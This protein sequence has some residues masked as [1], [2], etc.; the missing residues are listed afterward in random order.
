MSET[1]AKVSSRFAFL[2]GMEV[3]PML[4]KDLRQA[5]RSWTVIGAVL[6]LMLIFFGFSVAFLLN[7]EFSSRSHNYM[8]PELFGVVSSV[9]VFIT[10][11]FIPLYI[12]VRGMLERA[13]INGDLLYITTMSPGAIMRGKLISGIYLILLFYSTAVPFMVFSYLLRGIDLPTIALTISL[14]FLVNV[15]LIQAA[16]TLSVA[17]LHIVLKLLTALA[18]GGP[19]VFMAMAFVF[20]VSTAGFIGRA[21]S[22]TWSWS[23]M[24][25]VIA[26]IL[27]NCL[28]LITFLFSA[29]VAFISPSYANR[30][31][32]FR[33]SF[34]IIWALFL[35][36]IML[37]CWFENTGELLFVAVFGITTAL[38]IGIVL[39]ACGRDGLSRRVRKS[40]PNNPIGRFGSYFLFNGTLSALFWLAG[41]WLFTAV[42]VVGF[43]EIC[44]RSVTAANVPN[45]DFAQDMSYYLGLCTSII[46][47]TL[48][49]TLLSIF[50]QRTFLKKRHPQS[51]LVVFSAATVLPAIGL[52]VIALATGLDLMHEKFPLPGLLF[53][54]M[55]PN[56]YDYIGLHVIVAAVLTLIG[57]AINYKWV[58]KQFSQFQR[59][60]T[61]DPQE[62]A[63]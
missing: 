8:G 60:D 37:W 1:A 4:V 36:E 24:L 61:D 11:V 28:L 56:Q 35:M 15:I 55:L 34:T 21:F 20:G 6:L 39:S 43:V 52:V 17:P 3:N 49:Y 59:L 63:A 14:M 30:S 51:T 53:S 7:G 18:L 44:G 16:I 41:L 25:P 9:L 12:G 40:I 19:I 46:L 33:V 2:R 29:G 5:A 23:E 32:Q 62:E 10:F 27:G 38:A 42:G 13:S 47:Y 57:F 48:A 50:V 22:G 26:T 54:C 45:S 31:G 58:G